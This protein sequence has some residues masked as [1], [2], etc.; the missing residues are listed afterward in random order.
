MIRGVN[1]QIIEITD[2]SSDYYERALLIVKPEFSDVNRNELEKEA[3]KV[4]GHVGVKY[5]SRKT[6]NKSSKRFAKWGVITFICISMLMLVSFIL[7]CI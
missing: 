4:L 2:V 1:R 5:Y 7:R 3:T 6:K